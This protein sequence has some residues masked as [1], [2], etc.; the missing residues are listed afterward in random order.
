MDTT[1][2]TT[3]AVDII[4]DLGLGSVARLQPGDT[5]AVTFS[6]ALLLR[7]DTDRPS[8]SL[9]FYRKPQKRLSRRVSKPFENQRIDP[10]DDRSGHDHPGNGPAD[11]SVCSNVEGRTL[12]CANRAQSDQSGGEQK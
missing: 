6:K 4:V 9:A 1:K 7:A 5:V 12:H 11:Q 2:D 3:K 8:P 10:E